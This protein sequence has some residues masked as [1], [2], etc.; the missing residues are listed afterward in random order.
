MPETLYLLLALLTGA[1][2]RIDEFVLDHSLTYEDCQ[3]AM[4]AGLTFNGP[5]LRS[6]QGATLECREEE[7]Q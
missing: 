2:G 6:L 7:S 1:D 4:E 5:P 3:A